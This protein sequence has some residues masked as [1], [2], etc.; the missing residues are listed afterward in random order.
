LLCRVYFA[1]AQIGGAAS[2]NGQDAALSRL[3]RE[4]DSPRCYQVMSP[5][6]IELE[7]FEI[8]LASELYCERGGDHRDLVNCARTDR[9]RLGHN[10]D[11]SAV[12]CVRC[13]KAIAL[14]A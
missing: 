8:E 12:L 3:R 5:Q 9:T 14:R 1:N 11:E 7:G 2:S 10:V 4:L 6:V 13:M